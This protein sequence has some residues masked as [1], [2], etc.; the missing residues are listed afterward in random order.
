VVGAQKGVDGSAKVNWNVEEVLGT[1]EPEEERAMAK[2]GQKL[3]Q[4]KKELQQQIACRKA[5]KWARRLREQQLDEEEGELRQ[6]LCLTTSSPDLLT[7]AG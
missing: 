6:P 4:P 3:W 7:I 5:E 2:P 1:E